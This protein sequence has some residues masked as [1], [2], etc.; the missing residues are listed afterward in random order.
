MDGLGG[1]ITCE[2][3]VYTRRAVPRTEIDRSR[4][5]H[6]DSRIR[7]RQRSIPQARHAHARRQYNCHNPRHALE[8]QQELGS[9]RFG[10]VFHETVSTHRR[11]SVIHL[12]LRLIEQEIPRRFHG[13]R[14]I[15]D[16]AMPAMNGLSLLRI[17]DPW[18]KTVL[19]SGVGDELALEAFND[20]VI[21]RY[22]GSRRTRRWWWT[23]HRAAA[24]VFP[25][26]AAR[27]PGIVVVES[28]RA[29]PAGRA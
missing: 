5:T 2:S 21:D 4:H 13:S 14:S 25:R 10:S 27:H 23:T 20:G 29:A 6:I 19:M 12:D 8:H 9:A 7:R 15:A 16:F 24:R 28:A 26:P 11:D 1:S 17:S 3:G 18:T 22:R